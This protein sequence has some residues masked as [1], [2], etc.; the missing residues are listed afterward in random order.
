MSFF[1]ELK[2]RNV[3]RVGIAYAVV[4]WLLMQVTDSFAP[5]LRLPEWFPTAVAFL[6]LLGFPVAVFFSWAFEFTPEGIKRESEI[7]PGRSI[8]H[9]NA[10]KLDRMI[11]VALAAVVVVLLLDRYMG[12]RA[13]EKGSEPFS[14][15]QGEIVA[16]GDE[17][18]RALT[19]FPQLA[20][21]SRTSVAVLP[22]INMSD[23]QQNEYF[24]DGICGKKLSEI[25]R[26]LQVDHVLEGSVRKAGDR[27][28]VT[29]QLI[30][31]SSDAHLWSDTYTRKLDDI[32]AV[33]DEI[34]QAIVEAL[35]LTLSVGDQQKLAHHS[36]SNAEAYNKYLQG[37]HLWNE[38]TA[39]ALQASVEPLREAVEIDPEFDQAWA[40]LADAYVLFPEYAAGSVEESIPM[41]REA[42][43]K[44]LS[45]NPESA[46]ALTTRGYYRAMLDFNWTAADADFNKAIEH[47]PGYATAHQWYAEVLGAQGRMEEALAELA[48]AHKADPLSAV[49]RHTPGY[50][51]LYSGRFEEAEESFNHTIELDPHF[52]WT[53]QNRDIMYT[54]QGRFDAA[55]EQVR[56][57]ARV[58]DF[59]PAPDLARIDAVESPQLKARAL[60]LLKARTDIN[61][62]VF[63]KAM[64]AVLLNELDLALEYLEGAFEAGDPWAPHLSWVKLYDPLRDNPRFQAML[65]KM[66]LL[67]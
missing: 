12:G 2:R 55:R 36:T 51:L 38:R 35:K 65:K 64:Q 30:E 13:P 56:T 24:S 10:R 41:A 31:V 23:D 45:I 67:P 21:D 18:K 48:I 32:F 26:E 14:E 29:A 6:L 44:A 11:I 47:E 5:A 63:G 16:E 62:G 20:G 58:E 22:F 52:H 19:P 66:N 34:A 33:Q 59:D 7:E 57:L 1:E 25:G 3:F 46:R 49:I 54:I 27:I 61:D 9:Q 37:R 8:K 60:E 40:A 15:S 43:E 28:R 4:G 53:L 39:K 42:A 17:Q 50:F